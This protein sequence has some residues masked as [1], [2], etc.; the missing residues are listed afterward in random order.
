MSGLHL[1]MQG[2]TPRTFEQLSS[3]ETNLELNLAANPQLL[4]TRKVRTE[5]NKS[6]KASPIKNVADA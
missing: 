2:V 4:D 5:A 6:H 1:W 3:T